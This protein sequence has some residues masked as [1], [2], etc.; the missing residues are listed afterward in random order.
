LQHYEQ[1]GGHCTPAGTL[2]YR[3]RH[4]ALPPDF[5]SQVH[6]LEL[7]S[8]GLGTY[9]GGVDAETDRAVVDAATTLALAGCNVLDSA[10]NYRDGRAE[11]CIGE[12]LAL[13]LQHG[14]ERDQLFVSTKV[15]IVPEGLLSMLSDGTLLPHEQVE[16]LSTGQCFSPAYIRWQVE[17]SRRRLGLESIDCVFLHNVEEARA[18][19]PNGFP[20]LLSHAIETLEDLVAH[21]D[22]RSY[23]FATWYGLRVGREDARALSL[24]ELVA[25]AFAVAGHSHH[26]RYLQLPVG[27]WAPEA[28]TT[29]S[30]PVP[31]SGLETPLAAATRLGLA[32]V[33][34]APLLQ[35]ELARAEL[36]FLGGLPELSTAQ[37]LVQF[38]RSVPGVTTVL[39]GLKQRPHIEEILRLSALPRSDLSSLTL[40]ECQGFVSTA[41]LGATVQ[42]IV[43][44]RCGAQIV[45]VEDPVDGRGSRL[46]DNCDPGDTPSDEPM[47]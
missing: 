45:Y 23:G 3:S 17:Q 25:S 38:S 41:A 19:E 12:A 20:T 15:G 6:G 21:E 40:K 18:M 31:S 28:L 34:S 42:T 44:E 8:V 33:A 14:V 2:R 13:L 43:R 29:A 30:Q 4:A 11:T 39:V 26:L 46:P 24:C 36:G 16:V 27:L 47:R 32:V 1:L 5:F 10:P 22:I 35:G 7:S 37:R 9:L